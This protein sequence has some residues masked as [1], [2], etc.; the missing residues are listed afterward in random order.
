MITCIHFLPENVCSVMQTTLMNEKTKTIELRLCKSL[1]FNELHRFKTEVGDR[2]ANRKMQS[3]SQSDNKSIRDVFVGRS[4][5]RK[6]LPNIF[7]AHS[8]KTYVLL[9]FYVQNVI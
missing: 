4:Q 3:Y 6:L 8:I 7:N 2:N 1:L 5:F 9:H